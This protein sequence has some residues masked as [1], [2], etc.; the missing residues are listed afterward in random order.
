MAPVQAVR[1]FSMRTLNPKLYHSRRQLP[2]VTL[3]GFKVAPCVLLRTVR[4]L[5]PFRSS[6]GM[7]IAKSSAS[8]NITPMPRKHGLFISDQEHSVRSIHRSCRSAHMSVPGVRRRRTCP[9]SGLLPCSASN[10]VR[11]DQFTLLWAHDGKRLVMCRA[12]LAIQDG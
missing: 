8:M 10:R 5:D 1:R 3:S 9:E 6:L 4:M 12:H 2:S 7:R 11:E